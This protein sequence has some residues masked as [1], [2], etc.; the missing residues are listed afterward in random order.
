MKFDF[1]QASVE[2][3]KFLFNSFEE[4]ARLAWFPLLIK[5]TFLAGVILSGLHG[6]HL[7]QG[8]VLLPT[9]VVEGW[10]LACVVRLAVLGDR[11]PA[12]L[13][14]DARHD[15]AFIAQ[16][17]LQIKIAVATYVLI[18]LVSAAFLGVS[19]IY[20]ISP[21]SG[22]PAEALHGPLY[23]LFIALFIFVIWAFR[24]TWLYVPAA[25]GLP[26]RD[27]LSV[28]KGFRGSFQLLATWM[29]CFAPLFIIL[30]LLSD[31]VSSAFP[32]AKLADGPVVF[33]LV[34]SLMQSSFELLVAG[35]SSIA[36]AVGITRF[37]EGI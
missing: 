22:D 36:V 33:V 29:I 18:K 16:R 9:Y 3:Y 10:F 25:I 21:E 5:F 15:Q 31:I 8:L 26:F 19:M 13:T 20:F 27:F 4:L 23:F 35:V 37:R 1:V 17:Q 34:F 30:M 28:F 11:Y 7:R 2:S 6:D 14:G 12:S 24:Y 32:G